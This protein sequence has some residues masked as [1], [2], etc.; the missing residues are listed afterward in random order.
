M[1]K[2][3]IVLP[4]YNA[5]KTLEKTVA[6]IPKNLIS[7]IILVDDG[8]TDQTVEIARKLNLSIFE[9]KENRGYGA[10]QKTCYNLAR[11]EKTDIIIMIHPDYQ[12]DPTRIKYFIDLIDKDGFDVV[13]GSRIRSR[14]EVLDGGMP[15]YKYLAN[16]FLSF[17]ENILS[18]QNLS[19]WHTGMRAYKKDV[20]DKIDYENFSDDFVFD[21]EMLFAIVQNKFKI[22]ETP[23]PVR[24][25]SLSSSINIKRSLV[26]GFK[27]LGVALKF[28]IKNV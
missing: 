17:W 13:L 28:F 27:T 19:E 5:A 2:P 14:K 18:G 8:S 23:V 9:H 20:L 11:E 10:N 25:S 21:S 26:Y 6:D 16:R 15:V 22:G 1:L 4:A 24:Y 12:Y 7:K 3:I